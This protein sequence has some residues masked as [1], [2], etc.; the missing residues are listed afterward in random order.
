MEKS[1]FVLSEIFWDLWTSV[2]D[3][4]MPTEV[5]QRDE[6]DKSIQQNSHETHF[7]KKKN[8]MRLADKSMLDV[9]FYAIMQSI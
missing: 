5:C 3:R 9:E 6:K 4:S 1:T 2:E 7:Q 8:I